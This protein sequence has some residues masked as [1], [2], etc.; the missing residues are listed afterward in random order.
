MTSNNPST[1]GECTSAGCTFTVINGTTFSDGNSVETIEIPIISEVPTTVPSVPG[2]INFDGAI[3]Q[4]SGGV[5]FA[6][7][8]ETGPYPNGG[9]GCGGAVTAGSPA[10]ASSNACYIT[11][12]IPASAFAAAFTNGLVFVNKLTFSVATLNNPDQLAP[13]NNPTGSPT[14]VTLPTSLTFTVNV[15]NGGLLFTGP[16]QF[17]SP[18]GPVGETTITVVDTI[19]SKFLGTTTGGTYAA[20]ATAAKGAACPGGTATGGIPGFNSGSSGV[21]AASNSAVTAEPYVVSVL[22]PGDDQPGTYATTVKVTASTGQTASITY[23][24][25]VGN[26]INVTMTTP[27]LPTFAPPLYIEAGTA[28]N[29]LNASTLT[30][31][32]IGTLVPQAAPPGPVNVPFSLTPAASNATNEAFI[33]LASEGACTTTLTGPITSTTGGG[34]S[35]SFCINSAPPLLTNAGEY[36][37]SYTVAA[38][39]TAGDGA[40]GADQAIVTPPLASQ[41]PGTSAS[42]VFREQVTSGVTLE[43]YTDYSLSSITSTNPPGKRPSGGGNLVTG[44]TLLTEGGPFA[45]DPHHASTGVMW[46]AP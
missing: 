17:S 35:M 11:V 18:I 43:F 33:T 40:N 26:I 2:R 13:E 6:T 32:A 28:Q 24:L 38:T 34:G 31:T 22:N 4:V 3:S 37:P 45:L 30:V 23:C 7:L 12:Q 10:T 21:L 36:D 1:T 39:G 25:T 20:V 42:F 27:D 15:K 14:I 29:A 5:T 8:G 46:Q 9:V 19:D 16:N 44:A 41:T